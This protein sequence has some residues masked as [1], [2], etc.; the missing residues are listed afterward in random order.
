[1]RYARWQSSL[2]TG[3]REVDNQHR[4]LYELVNDL[5]ASAVLSRG[6][7]GE[8][9]AL[10]RIVSYALHHFSSEEALMRRYDYPGLGEHSAAHAEFAEAAEGLV[11]AHFVG[12]GRSMRE[13]AEF[14]EEWLETHITRF[15]QP[16]VEF[17]RAA[18]AE[19]AD[20]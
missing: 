20:A 3:D 19:D 7:K 2:E 14:M 17:V 18:Q 11:A 12:T 6:H 1:M 5:N 9:E 4:A 10:G 16:M 8:G 15:D 13:L